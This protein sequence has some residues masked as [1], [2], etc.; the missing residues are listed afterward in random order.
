M[1]DY[2][3]ERLTAR[4][5]TAEEA[6]LLQLLD[7]DAVLTVLVGV[8]QSSGEPITASML[9]L[10]GSRHEIKDS[11]PSAEWIGS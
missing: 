10:P 3:N 1:G 4:R 11:N 9:V 2:A 6:E 7:N 8:Y 5:A